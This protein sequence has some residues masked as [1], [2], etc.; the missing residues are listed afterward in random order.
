MIFDNGKKSK[1][2]KKR[3]S[4]SVL[5]RQVSEV[6]ERETR[7][8]RA[9]L[10]IVA[11]W[12]EDEVEKSKK[13]KKAAKTAKTGLNEKG[14]CAMLAQMRSALSA[15][16][17][18][19]AGCV[20]AHETDLLE[21]DTDLAPVSAGHYQELAGKMSSR[22]LL[23]IGS[24]SQDD[25]SLAIKNRAPIE[26]AWRV[27]QHFEGTATDGQFIFHPGD[28]VEVLGN[29]MAWHPGIVC[30][31][32]T[33]D[34]LKLA[35][36]KDGDDDDVGGG[37]DDDD[38]AQKQVQALYK[39]VAAVAGDANES[40]AQE[41][42][43]ELRAIKTDSKQRKVEQVNVI[44]PNG[45]VELGND[46]NEVRVY[47][48][49][50]KV[51]FGQVPF[52]WQQ[53]VLLKAE[54]KMRF[55]QNH[56]DDFY[57]M[58]WTEWARDQFF[59]WLED[60][61]DDDD[62][63]IDENDEEPLTL[64]SENDGDAAASARQR[65]ANLQDIAEEITM[66]RNGEFRRYYHTFDNFPGVQAALLENLLEPFAM[67]DQ[68]TGGADG[69]G[70]EFDGDDGV[71]CFTYLSVLGGGWVV[72]GGM[73]FI[74]VAIPSILWKH[75]TDQYS[76]AF[77]GQ[78]YTNL[79]NRDGSDDNKTLIFAVF[80]IYVLMV[81]PSQWQL[82]YAK[83]GDSQSALSKLSSLRTSVW[84]QDEDTL[85]QKIGYKADVWMNTGFVCGL[86]ILN[87]MIII[88]TDDTL[89]IVFNALAIEF[90]HQLDEMIVN[91]SWF[92]P[93]FRLLKAGAVELVIRRY[94][95]LHQLKALAKAY[96][97]HSLGAEEDDPDVERMRQ[98]LEKHAA[99]D[100]DVFLA[101]KENMKND[102]FKR[103]Q[104]EALKKVEKS[105]RAFGLINSSFQMLNEYFEVTWFPEA[106]IFERHAEKYLHAI[107]WNSKSLLFQGPPD[108]H[109]H[110]MHKKYLPFEAKFNEDGEVGDAKPDSLETID[111]SH[112]GSKL[113]Q[114]LFKRILFF[115]PGL[116]KWAYM[117][118]MVGAR[119]SCL[120]KT[121]Y[122]IFVV[123]DA[124][125]EMV[126]TVIQVL[127]PF[128]VVLGG[129][130]AGTVCYSKQP[131]A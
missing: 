95:N 15:H 60:D 104:G 32:P 20:P 114:E 130:F 11:A 36:T 101:E 115:V 21:S 45:E 18:A 123:V 39:F 129:L 59:Q 112:S 4:W 63:A 102:K 75:S 66:G 73:F 89:D 57:E 28:L 118:R 92:D 51:I 22:K 120:G 97:K 96:P 64:E 54:D 116:G 100:A 127:F 126:V 117:K 82:L 125:I 44:R 27:M 83:L 62:E 23:N 9:R 33:Y 80:L 61:D 38:S 42:Y 77:G 24:T 49:A 47:Q 35:K 76:D 17:G 8:A 124:V 84:E 71:S 131:G 121:G 90:V 19:I 70:W 111:Y 72:C 1:K 103:L 79:C 7:V 113:V 13:R 41:C 85:P 16:E 98:F 53:Y 93:D 31:A 55:D 3:D 6:E 30:Y 74:Q 26:D 14:M 119:K 10:G 46:A 67:M 52:L 5:R 34:K 107:D 99:G 86:Y 37:D 69:E 110:V 94:L 122:F 109:G 106:I 2:K 78:F 88:F 48:D 43:D 29:D 65:R 108:K 25:S 40:A 105:G 91:S 81:V 56:P 68:I 128:I 12:W 87:M 50:V 58:G